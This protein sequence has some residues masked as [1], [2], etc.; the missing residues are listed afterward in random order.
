LN[1][2]ESLPP[3]KGV[4]ADKGRDIA[5]ADTVLDSC[6]DNVGEISD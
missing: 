3:E 4:V 5:T 1:A 2:L 6:V